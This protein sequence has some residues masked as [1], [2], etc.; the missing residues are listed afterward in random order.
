MKRKSEQKRNF[1]NLVRGL[2]NTCHGTFEK[3]P[4][5]ALMADDH[6]KYKF[7]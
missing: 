3:K 6:A 1:K 7:G 5:L 4:S 2:V